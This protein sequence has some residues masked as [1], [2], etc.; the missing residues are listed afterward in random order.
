MSSSIVFTIYEI[1]IFTVK[2]TKI[3]NHHTIGL[4]ILNTVYMIYKR[5]YC[6]TND[7]VFFKCYMPTTHCVSWSYSNR[8]IEIGLL[9]NNFPECVY[10]LMLNLL[11]FISINTLN[12]DIGNNQNY[13]SVH[14]H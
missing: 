11:G 13:L 7:I 6:Y 3:M 12:H 2:L 1:D 14:V 4:P 8:T 10:I 9:N 5:D